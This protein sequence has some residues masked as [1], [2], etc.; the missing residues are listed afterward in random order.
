[1]RIDPALL[2]ISPQNTGLR[3]S[4]WTVG[5]V[6]SATVIGRE[7]K[8]SMLLRVGD[9]QFRAT[10]DV[11]TT[12][13]QRLMLEVKRMSPVPVLAVQK[14]IIDRP[15]Q[16]ITAAAKEVVPKQ[17]P[18]HIVAEQLAKLTPTYRAASSPTVSLP[19]K[20][21][22]IGQRLLDQIP[23]LTEILK[24]EA[25]QRLIERSGLMLERRIAGPARATPA[26]EL[27][28]DFKAQLLRLERS[29]GAAETAA[30]TG[31]TPRTAL[32]KVAS[33]TAHGTTQSPTPVADTEA[34]ERTLTGLKPN[35]RTFADLLRNIDAA[36]AKIETNQLKTLL[37]TIESGV[38]IAVDLPVRIDERFHSITL[39]IEG[40]GRADAADEDSAMRGL[41]EVPLGEHGS[42]L[43]AIEIVGGSVAVNFWS[44]NQTIRQLLS[45]RCDMFAQ[46]LEMAGVTEPTVGLRIIK[47]PAE[48]TD[49]SVELVNTLI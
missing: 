35:D 21:Q 3:V 37:M 13:G 34:A 28:T 18:I 8:N 39:L 24:P 26:P 10:G 9:Q 31:P 44:E 42:L 38:G 25:V 12:P 49:R 6:L 5:Q 30:P 40:D 32:A 47:P 45:S 19:E 2:L 23:R 33:N 20:T 17:R 29:L 4:N 46:R 48:W 14:P 16:I 43:A 15:R 27:D 36:L 22:Q 11:R 1:M 41:I 7:S